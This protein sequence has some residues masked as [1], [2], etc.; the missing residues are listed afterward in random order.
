MSSHQKIC[1]V[2]KLVLSKI[3]IKKIFHQCDLQ[4]HNFYKE[5]Y[6]NL[7]VGLKDIKHKRTGYNAA[8]TTETKL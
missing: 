6:E 4:C 8:L 1:V 7:P 5:C 2:S 3:E